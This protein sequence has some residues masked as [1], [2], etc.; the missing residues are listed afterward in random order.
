MISNDNLRRSEELYSRACDE[1]T[2]GEF[3]S[4]IRL[5]KEALSLNPDYVE[6]L[7]NLGNVYLG[8]GEYKNA[9][10]YFEKALELNSEEPILLNNA[11][12]CYMECKNFDTANAYYIKAIKINPQFFPAYS[13]CGK[14]LILKG[15]IKSAKKYFEQALEINPTYVE[16]KV[17]LDHAN[18]LLEMVE[19][20]G[21]EELD[22]WN[23]EYFDKKN[24]PTLVGLLHKARLYFATEQFGNSSHNFQKALEL[25]P[26][27]VEALVGLSNIYLVLGEYDKT[28]EFTDKALQRDPNNKEAYYNKGAANHYLRNLSEAISALS[29][30]LLL[31][32]SER[33]E[34]DGNYLIGICFFEKG[35]IKN[36]IIHLEKIKDKDNAN[37][38]EVFFAL[39]N[40]YFAD[41]NNSAGNQY[42]LKAAQANHDRAIKWRQGKHANDILQRFK[43]ELTS[44]PLDKRYRCD[45]FKTNDQKLINNEKGHIIIQSDQVI[46]ETD[47]ESSD[48]IIF[49]LKD[50][51]LF[52]KYIVMNGRVMV[53]EKFKR[54][55]FEMKGL[56][57][58]MFKFET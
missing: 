30:F 50:D 48:K 16:A 49:Y 53:D 54:V 39:A 32:D 7:N 5:F 15:E 17:K 20:L 29:K 57:F 23:K 31:A 25:Q 24:D 19:T 33:D 47:D 3:D 34:I 40:S 14:L 27:S 8:Q 35:D 38:G 13:N 18:Q 22:L 2:L 55:E 56:P 1:K 42:M 46:L 52:C 28:I 10:T 58:G 11:G 43:E 51:S 44:L 21:K 9:L 36:S 12:I 37:N 26:N 41:G 4:A 45:V 6:A